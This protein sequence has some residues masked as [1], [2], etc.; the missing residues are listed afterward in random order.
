M[1]NKLSVLDL[2]LHNEA[3]GTLTRLPD[4]RNIFSFNEEYIHNPRRAT[5]S[6]SFKDDLGN[7]ITQVKT[8][9]TRLQPFFANVLPEGFMRSYLAAHANV[10]PDREF[11]LLAALGN[12]LPGA[13]RTGQLAFITTSLKE[14][15]EEYVLRN[16]LHFSLT[17]LQLKFSATWKNK[18][19]LT[20]PLKGTGGNWIIKLPSPTFMGVPQ[21]EYSMMDLA[22]QIGINVPKT[23]LVKLDQIN[24]IPS[25]IERFGSSAFVIERF[26]RSANGEV[27]HIE[28][29]AQIFAIYPERKY[30][31]ASYGN[32][33][34]VIWAEVGENG[35]AEFI[36][37]LVFN[38]LIGNGDMH[39]KNWSLIY[40]DKINPQLAP[41][42][43]YVSTV[44]YLSADTLALNFMGIKN[45]QAITLESF[46]KFAAQSR[47]PKKLVID[48]AVDTVN[49]FARVWQSAGTLPIEDK[50]AE[51]IAIHLKTLPLW[52]LRA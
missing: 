45:F 16:A 6:L 11:F 32:I 8:T 47:L 36:R 31:A 29:F 12:D 9:R 30:S 17:G 22:R 28:D 38:I 42:Y 20:I 33:A 43:D 39:L 25:D 14:K 1:K 4:D 5:L 40:L 26:D 2:F 35:L 41:A 48:T 37:R 15:T 19:R 18:D 52:H 44:P 51:A 23:A 21:N 3:I 50:V 27:I 49:R 24:G 7:L 46:E 34:E 10:H 13:I